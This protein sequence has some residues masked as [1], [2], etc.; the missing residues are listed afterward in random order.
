MITEGLQGL[1][2]EKSL[3][4]LNIF[5]ELIGLVSHFWVLSKIDHIKNQLKVLT[6]T[7][8]VNRSL[9]RGHG[10]HGHK[11]FNSIRSFNLFSLIYLRLLIITR[12]LLFE[13]VQ[14]GFLKP[15]SGGND[16]L[17]QAVHGTEYS[18]GDQD[19]RMCS[20]FGEVCILKDK[21]KGWIMSCFKVRSAQSHCASHK[22]V[23][24]AIRWCCSNWKY[25]FCW[26]SDGLCSAL[27]S[28]S[29]FHRKFS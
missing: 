11:H 16:I 4:R 10:L 8:S 29:F 3:E 13:R 25:G 27:F 17:H 26:T 28:N 20:M 12:M 22:P 7:V 23:V 6:E 1:V 24:S 2:N 14:F 9:V 15:H 21:V 5:A 18:L 19:C